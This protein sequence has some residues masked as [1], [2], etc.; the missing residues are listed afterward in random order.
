[1]RFDYNYPDFVPD[2]VLTSD[3]LNDMFGYLDNQGRMTRSNLSG[4][5]IVC[6]LQVEVAADRSSIT[7]TKGVGVTS[8]GYLIRM[9]EDVKYENYNAYD[10]V[11]EVY[12]DRFVNTA[13]TP[14]TQRFPLLELKVKVIGNTDTPLTA[15]TNFNNYVVLLFVELL[16]T[17]SKNCDPNSCD[18][19]GKEVTATIKPL[20]FS[21]GLTPPLEQNLIGK[22]GNPFEFSPFYSLPEIRMPRYDVVN[23]QPAQTEDILNVYV[24]MLSDAFLDKVQAALTKA[25]ETFKNFLGTNA[26]NPLSDI[27][28]KFNF[29]RGISTRSELLYLQYHYDIISDLLEAY[30]EFRKLGNSILS[31]CCPDATL[32]PRHLLL[33]EVAPADTIARPYRHYF[34]YSPLFEKRNLIMELNFLFSR[35][36]KMKNN[37]G[38][39]PFVAAAS[40]PSAGTRITPSRLGS[41]PLSAKAIPY[42]YKAPQ[43]YTSWSFDKTLRGVANQNHS[44]HAPF[45]SPAEPFLATPLAFD[46]EEFNFFRVEGHIGKKYT[47]VISDITSLKTQN[48]LPIEVIALS[49]GE[50]DLKKLGDG[51][52][53][54]NVRD[55]QTS[56]EII[57]REWEATIGKMIEYL[58]DVEKEARP[59]F[60][61]YSVGAD[62]YGEYLVLLHKGKT[63][64]VTDLEEFISKAV[65][66]IVPVY[67]LIEK[68][69]YGFRNFLIQQIEDDQLSQ[70]PEKHRRELA[71]AE[72]LIDHFDEVAL[73]CLKGGFRAIIQQFNSRINEIYSNIFFK[74]FVQKHPGIQHKAGVPPGGTFILVYHNKSKANLKGQFNIRAEVTTGASIFV[75]GTGRVVNTNTNATVIF[76]QLSC[77]LVANSL[78]VVLTLQVTYRSIFFFLR[79]ETKELTINDPGESPITMNFPD[80]PSIRI[81]IQDKT[82]SVFNSLK[83]GEVIADFYLPYICSSDCTPIQFV[84]HEAVNLAPSANAGPDQNLQLPKSET[85]LDGSASKDPENRPLSFSW[86]L[87]S[88]QANVNISDSQVAKPVVSNLVEPGEYVFEL[89]VRDVE[90][91]ES[92]T[93]QVTVTVIEAPDLAPTANAGEDQRVLKSVASVDLVG[94]GRDPE[95]KPLTFSWTLVTGPSQVVFSSPTAQQTTVTNLTELGAHLFRFTV[96][97]GR[98]QASDDVIVT[99][100]PDPVLEPV[101]DA[102]GPYSVT[103]PRTFTELNGSESTEPAG[104][105]LSYVWETQDPQVSI[106]NSKSERPVAFNLSVAKDYKVL[107]KVSNEKGLSDDDDALI[108]VSGKNRDTCISL[109]EMIDDFLKFTSN[110]SEN[111]KAFRE[112]YPSIKEVDEYFQLAKKNKIGTQPIS[113]QLNFFA[114]TVFTVNINGTQ[115]RVNILDALSIWMRQLIELIFSAPDSEPGEEKSSTRTIGMR[116]YNMMLNF[117][118]YMGCIQSNLVDTSVNTTNLF[119]QIQEQLQKLDQAFVMKLDNNQFM[120]LLALRDMVN[121]EMNL[122][123]MRNQEAAK[124]IY[125]QVLKNILSH[126]DAILKM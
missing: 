126:L 96:S 105:P 1:M 67:E 89:T 54:C 106:F 34:I 72:D 60:N 49:T 109:E 45:T 70:N 11:K 93:D 112:G 82:N 24:N 13:A 107:L 38:I 66:F 74:P 86:R 57:R 90:G 80:G 71:L 37:I 98:Q 53:S 25:H 123:S 114:Q 116:L 42:Y 79:T 62:K 46:L 9:E 108:R 88:A 14:K 4:I 124:P 56:Y 115:S 78:P 51:N 43:L 64:M 101:A 111:F 100:A 121:A 26:A 6:G 84:I 117:A 31:T 75:A 83:N 40:A 122:I 41:G 21:K 19:K 3:H 73:T 95:N 97:D 33:G 81:T 104:K 113:T 23:T 30:Q 69:S 52:I 85:T 120:A 48:R 59:L 5:G 110:D 15:L 99:V 50:P 36:V 63:F 18:D 94:V 44:Y 12:Y 35:M 7:I 27:K 91:V 118:M 87:I 68:E 47:D 16:T 32:F 39:P 103:I 119:E 22:T 8:E 92:N 20:M 28:S 125:F 29:L 61:E 102:G 77:S 76:N 58:H 55:L 10:P 65:D 2:Q 17:Q